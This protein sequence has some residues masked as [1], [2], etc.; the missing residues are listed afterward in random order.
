MNR[1]LSGLALAA[2]L[3]VRTAAARTP[4]TLIGEWKL[5]SPPTCPIEGYVFG[6]KTMTTHQR[7]IRPN[8]AKD[9]YNTV[10]YDWEDPNK[11]IVI[12][13]GTGAGSEIYIMADHNHMWRANLDQC[14][15]V[16]TK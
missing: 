15:F 9:Y 6:P 2:L 12:G 8:P 7:A 14:R 3:A 5:E 11:A 10:T 13:Q 4:D 1:L 16:R